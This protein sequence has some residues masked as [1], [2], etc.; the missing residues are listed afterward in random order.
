MRYASKI[1]KGECP[2]ITTQCQA[3]ICGKVRISQS[4]RFFPLTLGT[5]FSILR[6]SLP[7]PAGRTTLLRNKRTRN[8]SY[9]W[10]DSV[11][12]RFGV[13]T[14]TSVKAAIGRIAITQLL[15][16]T[17]QFAVNASPKQ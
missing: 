12:S 15:V 1:N 11:V 16:P 2:R 9:Q 7:N 14:Q 3:E 5:L 17:R 13:F 6:L 4:R 8:R 10:R